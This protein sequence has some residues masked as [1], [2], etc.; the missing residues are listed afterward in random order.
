[1]EARVVTKNIEIEGRKF[2]VKKYTAMDGL[3][4]AKLILAKVIPIF[5]DFVPLVTKIS[6]RKSTVALNK[7][8]ADG[9]ASNIIRFSVRALPLQCAA[10]G[11]P[12]PHGSGCILAV[13]AIEKVSGEDF[14]YIVT[15]SLQN[16]SEVLPAGEAPVM[17][18]NGTYGVEGVEYDP[19]LVLRLTCEAVMWSCGDFF[20]GSRLTSVMSPLF[21]GYQQSR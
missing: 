10:S 5:Q 21:S 7:D 1:M 15:K 18:S 11:N 4:V 8:G 12:R 17:Y 13:P 19:I 6:S 3:K 14:D 9:S 16:I 2:V 20:D